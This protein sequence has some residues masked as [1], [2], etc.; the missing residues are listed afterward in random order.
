MKQKEQPKYRWLAN[1]LREEIRQGKLREGERMTSELELAKEYQLSRQ[2]VRQ[3]LG[4][5]ELEGL[6]TRRRG[7]GTYV[8]RSSSPSQKKRKIGVLA[9]CLTDYIVPNITK[10]IEEELHKDGYEMALGLTYHKVENEARI[11][12]MFLNSGI[13]GLIVEGCKSALPNPNIPL[14]RA[15]EHKGIPYVFFHSYYRE[16]HPVYVTTDDRGC[17]FQAADFLLRTCTRPG[18]VFQVD[19]LQGH[20]RYAGFAQ[21][22]LNNGRDLRDDAV[23]WF[24][25]GDRE[26]FFS[27]ENAPHV[28]KALQ[29]CDGVVCHNDFVACEVIRIFQ[30]AGIQVP[31]QLSV[32]GFHDAMFS[33]IV[34][35]PLTSFRHPKE[36]LGRAAAQK[37]V[38]MIKTGEREE[39][40]VM[41]MEL[42]KRETTR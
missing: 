28:L 17:G 2:T 6:L 4:M 14:Y 12:Q 27:K 23:L 21:G 33:S 36:D 34:P 15:L 19:D 18:G 5:L 10:G 24:T 42:V 39:S 3:A 1:I 30:E 25:T 37:L 7:S 26:R 41:P 22:V 40:L 11:L 16:L 32:I 8:G 9:S 13:D 38:H 29:N 35:L 20:E 31:E